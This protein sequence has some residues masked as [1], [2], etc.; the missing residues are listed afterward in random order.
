MFLLTFSFVFVLEN[1]SISSFFSCYTHTYSCT[2][3][4]NNIKG[5]LLFVLFFSIAH[6]LTN[7]RTIFFS[8]FNVIGSGFIRFNFTHKISVFFYG[9]DDD[10][11][12]LVSTSFVISS[13]LVLRR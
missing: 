12:M 3:V 9:D 6:T 11:R 13:W 7:A 10:Q 4:D 5:S 8:I 2:I 1:T